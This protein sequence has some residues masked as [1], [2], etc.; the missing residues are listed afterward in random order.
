MGSA[1]IITQHVYATSHGAQAPVFDIMGQCVHALRSSTSM[2]ESG[3]LKLTGNDGN[4]ASIL[5]TP[6]SVML[7][8]SSKYIPLSAYSASFSSIHLRDRR[9]R[10]EDPVAMCHK[11]V[12][13][14]KLCFMKGLV[15]SSCDSLL[16]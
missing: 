13:D 15:S 14:G 8:H 16:L 9:D 7:A 5:P 11:I 4:L 12:E 10:V 2:L 1:Y 6:L 3:I